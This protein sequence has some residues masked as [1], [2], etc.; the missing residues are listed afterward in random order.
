MNTKKV[1]DFCSIL[2]DPTRAE[3]IDRLREEPQSAG[4][5]ADLPAAS[6]HLSKLIDTGLVERRKVA[7]EVSYRLSVL[8][9]VAGTILR[10]IHIEVSS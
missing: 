2:S 10:Q 1:A 7:R 4:S 5:L 8:G 9:R 3:I 6:Y